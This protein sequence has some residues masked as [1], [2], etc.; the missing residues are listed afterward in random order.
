[1]TSFILTIGTA[2]IT[3]LAS[4][5]WYWVL[6]SSLAIFVF[7]L[8]LATMLAGKYRRE[9]RAVA[10]A[11]KI[12]TDSVYLTPGGQPQETT[13]SAVNLGKAEL[14]YE[15]SGSI[16]GRLTDLPHHNKFLAS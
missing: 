14:S 2:L 4:L 15:L 11:P 5:E 8:G 10:P 6:G 1:V 12:Q 9:E 3:F 7:G 16:V 13:I